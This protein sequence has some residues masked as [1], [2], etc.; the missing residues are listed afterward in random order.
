MTM[1][2]GAVFEGTWKDGLLNG[3]GKA[4]YADGSVYEGGFVDGR[5][6]GQ[7]R[8]RLKDGQEYEGLWETGQPAT[9][10]TG[11][12]RP[13]RPPPSPPPPPRT[14]GRSG[15]RVLRLAHGDQCRFEQQAMPAR[16]PLAPLGQP[17]IPRPKVGQ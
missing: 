3:P 6:Q 1:P 2:D 15:E 8:I 16:H 13:S 5:R 9:G 12:P 4:A 11:C 17:A 14:A 7:G 10:G